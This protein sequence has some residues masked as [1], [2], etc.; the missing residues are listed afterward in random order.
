MEKRGDESQSQ[1]RQTEI[2]NS[3]NCMATEKKGVL[4]APTPQRD[5]RYGKTTRRDKTR[6][7]A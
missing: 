5:I 1:Y 2:M 7:V 6:F 4:A 3:K